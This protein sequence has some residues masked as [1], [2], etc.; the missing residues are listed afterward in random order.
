MKRKLKAGSTSVMLP[1]RIYDSSSTSGAYLGSLVYNS[2]GLTAKYRRDGQSSWTSITL[3]SATAGTFTSGGFCQATSAPTGAYEFHPP[4]AALAAG[5]KWVE[6]EVYGATNMV[7]VRIEIELD[8]IDYQD[9]VRLGLTAFPNVVSGNAGAVL[10]S[11]TGTAQL[12]TTSGIIDLPAITANWLTT[13]GIADGAFTS[14]KFA[15]ASLNGKGDWSTYAGGDTSGVTTLLA[16]LT[17]IRAGYLDNLTFLDASIAALNNLSALAN[18]FGPPLLEIPDSSS[19]LFMFEVVIRD[20]EGK[21]V[22]LDASPTITA[23]NPSGTDRSSNLSSVSHPGTGRYTFTYSVA[24]TAAEESLK[25]SV[26]GTVSMEARYVVWS[27]AVVNYDTLTTL[28]TVNANVSTI[29]GRVI[30]TLASG[31]HQPQSG[32]AYAVVND[33]TYGNAAIRTIVAAI[34]TVLSGITSLANWLRLGFRKGFTNS[35]ALGEIN[36]GGTS[37]YDTT[38]DSLEAIRDR[39]DAAWITGSG[40]GGTGGSLNIEISVIDS[41]TANAIPNARCSIKS[42]TTVIDVQSTNGSGSATCTTDAGTYD[43]IVDVEGYASYRAS[44]TITGNTTLDPIK[45]DPIIP[46][47]PDD[48]NFSTVVL[49][50]WDGDQ[51]YEGVVFYCKITEP[52]EANNGNIYNGNTKSAT[53]DINGLAYFKAPKG[54]TITYWAGAGPKTDYTIPEDADD[55]VYPQNAIQKATP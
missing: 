40:G 9:T 3:A 20:Q 21:L 22:D 19:S 15:A 16:R 48:P 36:T 8:A 43:V 23:V 52:D 53:T 25:I 28:N 26:S 24:S 18:I 4:D 49:K 14:A 17:T 42:G 35:T 41:S 27:G 1:I 5:A 29:L 7:P 13:A 38:T 30:G 6:I 34:Q 11:G 51:A 54:G 2:S 45:L 55:T 39:G 33:V 44:I 12:K 31:T 47:A 37:A 32:D 46:I 10:T 50:A